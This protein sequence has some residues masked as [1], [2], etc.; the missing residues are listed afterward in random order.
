M[1]MERNR[2]FTDFGFPVDVLWMDIEWSQQN[3]E[4]GGY[5]YFVFNPQNFTN[6]EIWQM[7]SEIEAENRRIVVI[8]DPHI[9]V[10]HEYSL[11]A[12]G[13]V[14]QDRADPDSGDM[15]NIFV[16]TPDFKTFYGDC[17]PG[18]STWIDFLNENAQEY[19]GSYFSY[20]K[21][22]GSSYLYYFWNDMN[23]P[24]IF[25]TDTETMPL[26]NLHWKADGRSV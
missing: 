17:W 18:N 22:H 11:Y 23:E 15:T 1:I 19:W 5:E 14:L 4:V 3:S 2:N 12:D 24:A 8:V 16:R 7:N 6:G 9:K 26:D 21:F 20:E 13:M 25:S 10:S